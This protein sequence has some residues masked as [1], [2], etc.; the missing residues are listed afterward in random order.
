MK[1]NKKLVKEF[2]KN[3]KKFHYTMTWVKG[4]EVLKSYEPF[5][6]LNNYD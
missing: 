3:H 5:K 1:K 2:L 6:D 4:K